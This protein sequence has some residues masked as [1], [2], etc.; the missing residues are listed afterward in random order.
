MPT[1]AHVALFR[2]Y[3]GPTGDLSSAKRGHIDS[4]VK[5]STGDFTAEL[6]AVSIIG[7]ISTLD[8]LPVNFTGRSAMAIGVNGSSPG[9]TLR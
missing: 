6:L 5:T 7:A 2:G 8:T 4:S 3:S 9:P 1:T